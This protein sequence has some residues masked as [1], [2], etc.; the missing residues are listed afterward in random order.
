MTGRGNRSTLRKVY[1]SAALSTTNLHAAWDANLGYHGGKPA[2]D[3]LSYG[4]T[5]T[6]SRLIA[7]PTEVYA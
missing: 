4:T 1:P 3:R 5:F 2:T 6:A 7:I